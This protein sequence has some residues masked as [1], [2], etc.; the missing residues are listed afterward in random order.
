MERHP[1]KNARK[2]HLI[3]PRSPFWERRKET[4]THP[5]LSRKEGHTGEKG[6]GGNTN[7]IEKQPSRPQI[8]NGEVGNRNSKKSGKGKDR[9]RGR[10]PPQV[11]KTKRNQGCLPYRHSVEQGPKTPGGKK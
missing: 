5:N 4:G 1:R 10:G 9:G 3:K 11:K 6:D 8:Q 2:C 7:T